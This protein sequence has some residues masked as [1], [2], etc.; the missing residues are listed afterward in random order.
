MVSSMKQSIYRN[1]KPATVHSPV[2]EGNFPAYEDIKELSIF[3]FNRFLSLVLVLSVVISMVSYSMV[4]AKEEVI[5]SVHN[6]TNDLNFENVEL[7]N[8][9]DNARSFYNINDK[10]AKISFL[11]KADKIL[12]V[13]ASVLPPVV[14]A[15]DTNKVKVV[16]VS[17]F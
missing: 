4:V 10:I 7:Q 9:V 17:G 6:D 2:V 15:E 16:P 1:I 8:K 12:E 5:I 11:Q 13:N 3:K 14:K